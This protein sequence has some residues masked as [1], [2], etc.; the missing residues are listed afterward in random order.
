MSLL[1]LLL[2]A[3]AACGSGD[4]GD[5]AA[6]EWE[7]ADAPCSYDSDVVPVFF[8]DAF[9]ALCVL[10][11][12][13]WRS[14]DG[15][16]WEQT[17]DLERYVRSGDPYLQSGGAFVFAATKSGL[18]VR[19]GS[20]LLFSSDG[21]S[22]SK[23]VLP[24]DAGFDYEDGFAAGGAGAIAVTST[25]RTAWVS[26]DGK[27]YV[28]TTVPQYDGTTT[29]HVTDDAFVLT[30]VELPIS[31]D[32]PLPG[33]S[34]VAWYSAD[35]FGWDRTPPGPML[36]EPFDLVDGM[37]MLGAYNRSQPIVSGSSG[38]YLAVATLLD[39]SL[40]QGSGQLGSTVVRSPDGI[41]WTEADLGLAGEPVA[42]ATGGLGTLLVMHTQ[43]PIW[44]YSADG[45]TGWEQAPQEVSAPA[46]NQLSE[47]PE[48]EFGFETGGFDIG[49]ADPDRYTMA[50]GA[51]AVVVFD[52]F[53]PGVLAVGT[54]K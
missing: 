45:R 51:N 48:T 26:T 14:A 8:T 18:V 50:V 39:L 24:V 19:T 36:E 41:T 37:S 10:D 53:R 52:R 6:L 38:R 20:L 4:T 31:R 21:S 15:I 3:T 9:F 23:G 29:V 12:T 42:T 13:V 44:W 11:G 34:N 46:D 43:S 25:H 33:W 47:F 40:D 22:W 5:G 27:T 28:E 49:S 35:G 1:A 7:R 2:V 32:D 30:A 54:A 17:G 16:V